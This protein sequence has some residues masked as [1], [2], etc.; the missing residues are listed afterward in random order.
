M[1]TNSSKYYTEDIFQLYSDTEYY[2]NRKKQDNIIIAPT[3]G[4]A[5]Q[6]NVAGSRITF[7]VNNTSSYLL[8]SKAFIRCDFEITNQAGNAV[9][10]T[11][12]TLEHNFFP[13][14]FSQF[15]LEAG[16]NQ[17]EVIS[18]PGEYDTILKSVLYPKDYSN[19][20]GWIPDTGDGAIVGNLTVPAND[21]NAEA[22]RTA[23]QHFARR[24]NDKTLNTGYIKRL[25]FYNHTS[26]NKYVSYIHWSLY[27]LFGYLERDK[28]TIN[29]P[30]KLILTR[31]LNDPEIFY[32]AANSNAKLTITRL[33]L[34][35][36]QITP[37]IQVESQILNSLTKDIKFS[38]LKRVAIPKY[39][40]SETTKDWHI[41]NS[42]NVPRYIFVAFKQSAAAFTTNNAKFYIENEAVG[43]G[44]NAIPATQITKLQVRLNQDRYP[45]EPVILEPTQFN[46]ISAYYMYKEMCQTFGLITQFSPEEWRLNYPIFCFD[47][48]AH[49]ENL[50]KNGVQITVHIEK[51]A[52]AEISAFCL[53]LEETSNVIKVM[54]KK[55]I[56]I[57]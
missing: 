23:T 33:E 50:N 51:S 30:Y 24:L 22:V 5:N 14:L 57:E 25:N 16:S 45:L 34:H 8:L 37:S 10:G 15:V 38:Y 42:S 4:S 39:T 9:P 2:Y 46:V 17:I 21:A 40:F 53:I 1:T 54:D 11:T 27:P 29:L 44:A 26:G 41:S 49:A 7:E 52:A 31:Q 19:T 20:S 3:T 6:L 13:R 55:M 28:V 12:I 32:G 47:V 43:Q 56:R 35:I 36:P 48:T 18:N